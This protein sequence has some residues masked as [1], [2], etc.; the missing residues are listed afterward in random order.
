MEFAIIGVAIRLPGVNDIDEFHTSLL[1]GRSGLRAVSPEDSLR[2]GVTEAEI[3]NPRYV[4]VASPVERAELF[5]RKFFG[6]TAGEAA[7][8]DPQHRLLL[9]LAHE[10]LESSGLDPGGTPYRYLHLDHAVGPLLAAFR[11]RWLAG[12][13][14]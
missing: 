11:N 7:S 3:A 10:A 2:N 14:V 1:A 5:D 9:T 8:I 4:P 6:M 13:F 12:D